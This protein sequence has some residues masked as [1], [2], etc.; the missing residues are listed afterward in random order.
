LCRSSNPI[1]AGPVDFLKTLWQLAHFALNNALPSCA[2]EFRKEMI[3]RT[4][5]KKPFFMP[6]GLQGIIDA[7]KLKNVEKFLNRLQK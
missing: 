5:T 3:A 4:T 6:V 7:V 2:V 1:N